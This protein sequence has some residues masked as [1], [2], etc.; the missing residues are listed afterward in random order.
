MRQQ[1]L[2][3]LKE[4]GSHEV[5]KLGMFILAEDCVYPAF[6]TNKATVFLAVEHMVDSNDE[7]AEA[8]EGFWWQAS[9]CNCQ[10]RLLSDSGLSMEKVCWPNK[11]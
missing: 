5:R 10:F 7:D 4:G 8:R 11:P 9:G 1:E 2:L 3:V 6:A